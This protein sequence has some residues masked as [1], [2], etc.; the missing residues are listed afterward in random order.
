[1][2]TVGWAVTGTAA[3][4]A[5]LAAF[6]VFA[7]R[8]IRSPEPGPPVPGQRAPSSARVHPVPHAP[9][10]GHND[11]HGGIDY[12]LRVWN[13]GRIRLW[14]NQGQVTGRRECDCTPHIDWDAELRGEVER[15]QQ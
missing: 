14:N 13:C 11:Q 8:F 4:L 3:W 9:A 7:G 2:S 10:P 6:G 5:L 12:T 15:R 1:M